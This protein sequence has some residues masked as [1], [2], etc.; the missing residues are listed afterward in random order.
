MN[1]LRTIVREVF[2]LF[3]DDGSLALLVLI[4]VALAGYALPHAGWAP[5]WQGPLF[6]LGLVGI[7]VGSAIRYA[8]RKSGS[9]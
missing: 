9:R 6:F 7:L 2:G 4:W 5:R 3:V 8:R 1:A